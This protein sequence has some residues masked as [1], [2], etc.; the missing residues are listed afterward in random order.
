VA[1][2]FD[3]SEARIAFGGL[4]HKPW[5]AFAAERAIRDGATF[6]AAAD[7]ELAEARP[8]SENAYKIPLAR[9]TMIQVLEELAS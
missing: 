9:A 8:L 3:G 2:T 1:A 6:A 4:A 5:R 7:A